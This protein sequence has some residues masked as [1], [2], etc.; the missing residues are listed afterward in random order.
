MSMP[1]TE[2]RRN[3]YS[4]RYHFRLENEVAQQLDK[5]LQDENLTLPEFIRK[6][7]EERSRDNDK[8]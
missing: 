3:Q 5:Q 4:K 1:V 2:E 7:I 8:T 6:A